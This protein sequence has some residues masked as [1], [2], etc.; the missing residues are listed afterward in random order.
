MRHNFYSQ[1][2]KYQISIQELKSEIYDKY[3]PLADKD[4]RFNNIMKDVKKPIKH[5]NIG[6]SAEFNNRQRKK[7]KENDN[8]NN[9]TESSID[10]VNYNLF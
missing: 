8:S 10:K 4:T 3:Y 2:E 9:K 1:S 6:K 5:N 7:L